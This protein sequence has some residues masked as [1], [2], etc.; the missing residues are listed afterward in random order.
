MCIAHSSS[1]K[2]FLSIIT[3]EL[4]I[5]TFQ[6][7]LSGPVIKLVWQVLTENLL[8]SRWNYSMFP[9]WWFAAWI[10]PGYSA[11]NAT[12][13]LERYCF[14]MI[15]VYPSLSL[16]LSAILPYSIIISLYILEKWQPITAHL[17]L[18]STSFVPKY[19]LTWLKN[20][21][22]KY[23]SFGILWKMVISI[24]VLFYLKINTWKFRN[25]ILKSLMAARKNLHLNMF[26]QQLNHYFE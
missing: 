18:N 26:K 8:H 2:N 7:L 4:F 10:L 23:Q 13:T 15:P 17:I 1:P 19:H 5:T 6:L 12:H 20:L 25:C 3:P 16:C 24:W 11:W 21:E 22:I 14:K 9:L